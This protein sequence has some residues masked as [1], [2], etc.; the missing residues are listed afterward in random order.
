MFTTVT[1]S[2]DH[3]APN[4]ICEVILVMIQQSAARLQSKSNNRSS[5]KMLMKELKRIACFLE[6]AS[7]YI[8]EE[9]SS[10]ISDDAMVQVMILMTE[11]IFNAEERPELLENELRNSVENHEE[12]MLFIDGVRNTVQE[13]ELRNI[14]ELIEY[15]DLERRIT[16]EKKTISQ[17]LENQNTMEY[18]A[19]FSK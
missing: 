19:F 13:N 18:S 14:E 17:L 5:F 16:K 2:Q 3:A 9:A 11:Y 8:S 15:I 7:E 1:K 4:Q 12:V 10:E 6:K